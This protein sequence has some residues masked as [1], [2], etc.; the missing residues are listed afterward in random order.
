MPVPK[1]ALPD[2]DGELVERC[3]KGDESAFE[4]LV[5]KYQQPVFNVIYH[6]T[7]HATDIEDIA[8]KIFAKI[9]FSL[10]KFEKGRPFSP[11]LYRIA[12]NQCYDE[13]RRR[14]RRKW[15][16]FSEMNL[17]D[18]EA[19]DAVVSKPELQPH[20]SGERTHLHGLLLKLLD[21]LPRQQ[22]TAVILRD[23]EDVPYEKVASILQVSEQAARLK[24]FR[25]RSRL[26]AL[27]EKALL[28]QQ[29]T[30]QR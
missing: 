11:W 18:T 21:H 13:L 4:E 22:R 19:I 3:R 26:R 2:D 9:Y 29:R 15:M 20:D 30:G 8:Q 14:K 23:L 7:G 17:D 25:G 6:T 12:V 24:V 27:M 5:R 10:P 28:R 1:D 16:T